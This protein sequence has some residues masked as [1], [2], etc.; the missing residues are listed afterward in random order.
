MEYLYRVTLLEV[1]MPGNLYE[2]LYNACC[3]VIKGLKGTRIL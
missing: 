1:I 2:T 3:T